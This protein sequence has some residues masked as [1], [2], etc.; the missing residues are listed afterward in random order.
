VTPHPAVKN[1]QAF[2]LHVKAAIDCEVN[3]KVFGAESAVHLPSKEALSSN[4]SPEGKKVLFL[5]ILFSSFYG[6][7]EI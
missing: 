5:I 1:F 3:R 6:I 4:P 7:G 2:N